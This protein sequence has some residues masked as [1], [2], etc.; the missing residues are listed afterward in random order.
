MKTPKITRVGPGDGEPRVVRQV[1]GGPTLVEGPVRIECD[2]GT[3][4]ESDRFV[5]AVCRCR[6]S[7]IH[8][9]CDT[10]HRAL[11]KD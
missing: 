5:V 4:V 3:A 2:D 9:L 8:P 6:R 10:S 11:R 7:A 1:R